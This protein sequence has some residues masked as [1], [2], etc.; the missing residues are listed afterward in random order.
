MANYKGG[1]IVDYL[2]SI[3]GVSSYSDR[4][5]L[6]QQIGI[7]NY[8]GTA[9]QNIA[10]LAMLKNNTSQK[11]NFQDYSI[12][13]P[14]SDYSTS[15]NL[16]SGVAQGNWNSNL[17]PNTSYGQEPMNFKYGG[18][19]FKKQMGGIPNIDQYRRQTGGPTITDASYVKKPN[20]NFSPKI[21][22]QQLLDKQLSDPN[23]VVAIPYGGY[24][25]D[26]MRMMVNH[27]TQYGIPTTR[28][29]TGTKGFINSSSQSI[30]NSLNPKVGDYRVYND[31]DLYNMN[32][33]KQ[34]GGYAPFV[35]DN[36]D[37]TE[38]DGDYDDSQDW[39]KIGGIHINPKNKGKF[40][41]LKKRTGKSTEELTHSS[42]P[43][44]RKR[45]VFAQNASHWKH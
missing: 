4:K 32:F 6:A 19:L 28:D 24:P 39:M 3:H 18:P 16:P 40:T 7:S 26:S 1:S 36:I 27:S 45:A 17:N 44:T 29:F 37:D 5:K 35:E 30:K 22:A 9:S 43:L 21:T 12:P 10:L 14:P 11:R 23:A 33:K 13:P 38:N 42:N 34:A 25:G 41:A 8:S 15:N 2:K 20:I 31:S